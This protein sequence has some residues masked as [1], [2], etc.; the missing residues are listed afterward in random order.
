MGL[1]PFWYALFT[2]HSYKNVK[3]ALYMKP[4]LSDMRTVAAELDYLMYEPF[5]EFITMV[6]LLVGNISLL[7][8]LNKD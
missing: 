2:S 8:F 3:Q 6:F 4:K 1:I 5:K 7:Y